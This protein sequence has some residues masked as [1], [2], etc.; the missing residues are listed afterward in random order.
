MRGVFDKYGIIE[1]L[2]SDSGPQFTSNE[3]KQFSV[4]YRSKHVTSSLQYAQSNGGIERQVQTIKRLFQKCKELGA[5]PPPPLAILCLRS[6]PLDQNTPSSNRRKY[7]NTLPRDMISHDENSSN[8]RKRQEK[9]RTV[10]ERS[11]KIL[12]QLHVNDNVRIQDPVKKNV[13]PGC[14][15]R[16][17]SESHSYIV[18]TEN[19]VSPK[20][21]TCATH[22]RGF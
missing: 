12:P 13:A 20:P 10:Y 1:K 5:D 17:P 15:V 11:C 9:S 18:Q 7:C 6:T 3:F 14:I 19:G 2:I 16:P 4:N 8:L 21:Q 22:S